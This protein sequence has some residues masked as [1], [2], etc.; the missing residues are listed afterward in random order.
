M[1]QASMPNGEPALSKEH[2]VGGIQCDAVVGART[3]VKLLHRAAV[4]SEGGPPGG[5]GAD[6][7]GHHVLLELSTKTDNSNAGANPL[8]IPVRPRGLTTR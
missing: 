6:R 2:L 1:S 7:Y 5:G 8:P 3:L 4:G